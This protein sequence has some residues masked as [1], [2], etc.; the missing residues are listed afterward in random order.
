M[1][2]LNP[3]GIISLHI[4]TLLT[5]SERVFPLNMNYNRFFIENVYVVEWGWSN[6]CDNQLKGNMI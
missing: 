5:I 1:L 4:I 2:A 3:F 6:T